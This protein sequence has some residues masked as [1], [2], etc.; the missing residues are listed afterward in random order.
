[1]TGP[2]DR[3]DEILPADVLTVV[4]RMTPIPTVAGR[5]GAIAKQ[6]PNFVRGDIG[7]VVGL[8]PSIEVLYGPPVG[9][10]PLREAVA[11]FWTRTFRLDDPAYLGHSLGAENV[12]IT[13]GAAEALTL[14][15]RCFGAGKNVGLPR[16]YWENYLNGVGLSG[17][18]AVVVD[19]FA[20]SGELDLAGLGRDV[21]EKNVKCLVANFPCNPT[22]AVLTEEDARAIAAFLRERDLILIADEVYARLRFDGGA[23]IS[24]LAY[25]PERVV[26]LSSASKEYLIP[27]ARIGYVVSDRAE[28]TNA[29]LRKLVRANTA[30]PNVPGQRMVLEMMTKDLE[31]LRAGD[32]PAM[33][34][35]I[36]AE[37][38]QRKTALVE[39][40]R[41]HGFDVVG[42]PG[43][44]PMGTIFLMASLPNWWKD[45][46]EEFVEAALER[47]AFSAIP[48]S[49]FGLAGSVRFSFGSMSLEAVAELDRRLSAWESDRG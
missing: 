12:T 22:G 11:E 21:E 27:G 10:E 36:R 46:D 16:G 13:T 1:M 8:D 4:H 23:P 7:Q 39:V 25:A 15:F 19:Y 45:G 35:K 29:V 47:S 9:L 34:K 41:K 17:G 28:L 6:D 18:N 43:H 44:E 2:F 49:A 31:A 37:L 24:L 48:G 32:E 3:L 14:L 42:R 38:G 40:L 5:A 30:S 33:L 20:E 26:S